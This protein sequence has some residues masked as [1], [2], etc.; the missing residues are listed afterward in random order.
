MDRKKQ[1]CSQEKT[2][3]EPGQVFEDQETGRRYK[4]ISTEPDSDLGA[5]LIKT[6]VTDSRRPKGGAL[7]YRT[8]ERL[9]KMRRIH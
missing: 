6:I 2:V 7:T 3:F 9:L 5:G 1:S 4:V 8:R